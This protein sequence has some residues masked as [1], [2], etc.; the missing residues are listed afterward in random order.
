MKTDWG[1]II[2]SFIIAVVLCFAI[3]ACTQCSRINAE[4]ANKRIQCQEQ[5]Q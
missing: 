3:H 4:Q 5:P 2:E 1:S